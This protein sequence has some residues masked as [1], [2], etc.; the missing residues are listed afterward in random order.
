MPTCSTEETS[1]WQLGRSRGRRAR[2]EAERGATSASEALGD[3]TIS[4]TPAAALM[5]ASPAK[6]G[7]T[8]MAEVLARTPRRLL[9]GVEDGHAFELLAALPGVMPATTLV[10]Y[11]SI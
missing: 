4:F 3:P 9:H 2:R 5:M 6:A 11:S 1:P 10:P 8:K 7:G